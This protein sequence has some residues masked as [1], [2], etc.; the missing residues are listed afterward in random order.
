MRSCRRSAL[1]RAWSA[2]TWA[3]TRFASDDGRGGVEPNQK[4]EHTKPA[5]LPRV[6]SVTFHL[7]PA[8]DIADGQVVR[9]A[10]VGSQADATFPDPLEAARRWQEQ[11]ARWVH[12]VDLDAAFARGTN[13]ELIGSLVAELDIRVELA[14]GIAD[15]RSLDNALATGCER[16][17]LSTASLAD[18]Q[19]CSDVVEAHGERVAVALDVQAVARPDG[20]AQYRLADR[21]SIGRRS[22]DDG[23]LWST[24]DLLDRSG[25]ARYVVTDVSRDGMLTGPNMELYEAVAN[26]T[27]APVIASGGIATLD[28]LSALAAL[29]SSGVKLEG[30]IVGK[31][32]YANR[33]TLSDA[34]R[35]VEGGGAGH[36]D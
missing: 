30:A 15:T 31:A 1:N 6:P 7:L 5:A 32:L 8:V 18:P 12:V 10:Q 20:S 13:E 24:L 9:L 14:G 25:C 2:T 34:L 4:R 36:H 27:S 11:G 28:D 26:A 29:A 33:F 3:Q 17:V 19:W 35:S 23:E 22:G 21:G 16:V